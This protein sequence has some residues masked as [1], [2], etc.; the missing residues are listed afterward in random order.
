M[1]SPRIQYAL[2]RTTIERHIAD[3]KGKKYAHLVMQ[4][5]KQVYRYL[6]KMAPEIG[7]DN[8][9]STFFPFCLCILA[10][11]QAD[12]KKIEPDILGDAVIEYLYSSITKFK[13]IN[14]KTKR[15]QEV[16]EKLLKKTIQY[17][18]DHKD[19]YPDNYELEYEM[20]DSKCT[21][22]VKRSPAK[23]LIKK[24]GATK[25]YPQF[26]RIFSAVIEIEKGSLSYLKNENG[27]DVFVIEYKN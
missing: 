26:V 12:D 11:Y 3:V 24:V 16:L 4:K 8:P 14:L 25:I 23:A 1:A 6:L 15:G 9:A 13:R 2:L 27:E 18:I 19:V 22:T 20:H 10:P 21:I 7:N 17:Q 5:S